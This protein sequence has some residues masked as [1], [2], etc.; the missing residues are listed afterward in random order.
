VWCQDLEADRTESLTALVRNAS[1][2]ASG[3]TASFASLLAEKVID[4]EKHAGTPG[5]REAA[6]AALELMES[7]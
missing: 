7:T 3:T 5:P 1:S 4:G 2:S 6:W